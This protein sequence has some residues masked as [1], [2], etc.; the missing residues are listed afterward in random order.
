MSC[1]RIRWLVCVLWRQGRNVGVMVFNLVIWKVVAEGSTEAARGRAL[2]LGLDRL[3]SFFLSW[4]IRNID[5]S[6]WSAV[7][8]FFLNSPRY[9]GLQ[10]I[11]ASSLFFLTLW[12][13][14][15]KGRVDNDSRCFLKC[16]QDD[17]AEEKAKFV[18]VMIGMWSRGQRCSGSPRIFRGASWWSGLGIC[19]DSLQRMPP[20]CSGIIIYRSVDS[21]QP[22]FCFLPT[23]LLTSLFPPSFIVGSC[24][25]DQS[26]PASMILIIYCRL[27]RVKTCIPHLGSAFRSVLCIFDKIIF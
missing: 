26:F 15:W 1:C 24:A 20:F 19:Q 23:S 12:C 25:S 9:S 13:F 27:C 11:W 22:W 21:Y 7:N 5:G 8:L 17:F 6:V 3:A 2:V 10:P 4:V 16:A 14:R 18:P